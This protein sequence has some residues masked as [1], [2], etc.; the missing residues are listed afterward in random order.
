[1]FDIFNKY[2]RK[3]KTSKKIKTF[4]FLKKI[5]LNSFW[6]GLIIGAA[7]SLFINIATF[8]IQ[9]K[10]KMQRVFEAL[11][12]EIVNNYFQAKNII[13]SNN[14]EIKEN[15]NP[16]LFHT[17]YL[18]FN[19]I[20]TQSNESLEYIIQTDPKIQ[21]KIVTYYAIAIRG[22]NE[23]IK[24]LDNYANNV[25]SNCYDFSKLNNYDK[26]ICNTYYHAVLDIENSSADFILKESS[27]LLN[28]FHPTSDRQKNLFLKFFMGNKSINFLSKK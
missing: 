10:I 8:K 17:F 28:Y 7:F 1:M 11:E 12:N 24:Q 13:D 18:Y 19:D 15:K 16:S 9:E 5:H 22:N 20:W 27:D 25:L 26:K 21:S 3:R 2:S 14:N 4:L 23:L 6:N